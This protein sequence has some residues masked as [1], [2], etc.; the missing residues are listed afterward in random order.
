MM[1]H[2]RH[3]QVQRWTLAR[4]LWQPARSV[5]HR[6]SAGAVRA[7]A[8]EHAPILGSGSS[9]LAQ[10][11]HLARAVDDVLAG[12]LALRA[13]RGGG[14]SAALQVTRAVC[15]RSVAC[16]HLADVEQ[17]DLRQ[18]S[19]VLQQTAEHAGGQLGEGRVGGREDSVVSALQGVGEA[20][21]ARTEQATARVSARSASRG[22][23]SMGDGGVAVGAQRD[24][25]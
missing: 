14:A 9:L 1:R 16:A 2:P 10:R 7:A 11:R 21:V 4:A 22:F 23:S 20:C 6:A 8:Q 3:Q 13:R 17:Q 12:G 25:N 19:F 15:A 5:H 24:A 18:A